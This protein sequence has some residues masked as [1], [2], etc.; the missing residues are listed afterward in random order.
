MLS[1]ELHIGISIHL[2]I[3][4]CWWL[5]IKGELP[6]GVLRQ[7][8]WGGGME[9]LLS[10]QPVRGAWVMISDWDLT[11]VSN[12]LSL[13]TVPMASLSLNSLGFQ[14]ALHI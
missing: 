13:L 8:A 7:V 3:L 4:S 5:P 10:V 9:S 14:E 6:A 12:S 1:S 11:K 2:T